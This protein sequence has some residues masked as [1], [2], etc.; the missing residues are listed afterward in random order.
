MLSV[1]VLNVIMLSVVVLIDSLMGLLA[2]IR[3]GLKG[4][5]GTNALAYSGP[6]VGD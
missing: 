5:P 3:S 1:V 2:N 4:L 6:G